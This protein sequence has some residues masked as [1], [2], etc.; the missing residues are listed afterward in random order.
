MELRGPIGAHQSVSNAQVERSCLYRLCSRKQRER[1]RVCVCGAWCIVS[2]VPPP[3][4]RRLFTF[5]VL[6]GVCCFGPWVSIR[7]R[8]KSYFA[9]VSSCLFFLPSQTGTD[10][11]KSEKN[12]NKTISLKR[13]FWREREKIPETWPSSTDYRRL[14]G[15]SWRI[16]STSVSEWY[17]TCARMIAVVVL[18]VIFSVS[19]S[20][21]VYLVEPCGWIIL[22][23]IFF[24]LTM[25]ECRSVKSKVERERCTQQEGEEV[26]T[27]KN[28]PQWPIFLLSFHE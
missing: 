25:S 26:T 28:T 4:Y 15:R 27:G 21:R 13:S 16:S 23:F 5:I 24:F 8:Q 1:E 3:L 22:H 2:G 11:N 19:L 17:D 10:N 18:S 12:N 14:P 20:H 7:D 6:S 9:L